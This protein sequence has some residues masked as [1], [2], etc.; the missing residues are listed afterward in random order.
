MQIQSP[1]ADMRLS[2]DSIG[3]DGCMVRLDAMQQPGQ[4]RTTA[5]LTPAEVTK[6]VRAFFRPS[7]LLYLFRIGGHGRRFKRG[8]GIPKPITQRTK[9][10][11]P[12]PW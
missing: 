3:Q 4:V 12:T 2:I 11:T 9:H 10:P 8:I 1:L 6:F 5:Y 7:L